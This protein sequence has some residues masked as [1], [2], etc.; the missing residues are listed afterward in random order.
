MLNRKSTF[1]GA[2]VVVMILLSKIKR[3][4]FIPYFEKVNVGYLRL[5][6]EPREDIWWVRITRLS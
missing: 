4:K 3:I 2:G 6:F 5:I 1:H